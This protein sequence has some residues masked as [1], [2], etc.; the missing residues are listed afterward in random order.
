[1]GKTTTIS[2]S[3]HKGGSGKSSICSNL[4][5]S[6]AQLGYKVLLIDTDSQKNLSHSYNFIQAKKEDKNKNFH[7][8]LTSTQIGE[9]DKADLRNHILHTE[10][11]NIDIVVGDVSLATIENTMALMPY[12]EERVSTILEGIIKDEVYDFILFDTSPSLGNLSISI[13]TASDYVIVPVLPSTFGLEGLGVFMSHFD[14]I[15]RKNKKL[16]LLGVV[17]NQ[18][19]RRES[20]SFEAPDVIREVFGDDILF[21]TEII[22]DVKV[23]KAQAL[24]LPVAVAFE[25]TRVVKS[26]NDLAKEVIERVKKD[27]NKYK[28]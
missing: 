28:K 21:K 8:A 5:Y 15:R 22:K 9:E 13:L 18:V 17:M 24:H 1:M 11:K 4:G 26:Y 27:Q 6:I 10:Y 19:D 25:N 2:I 20:V 23:D 16:Q 3:T 14:N 7:V 12:R